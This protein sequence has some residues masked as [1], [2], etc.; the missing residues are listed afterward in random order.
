MILYEAFTINSRGEMK[1]SRHLRSLDTLVPQVAATSFDR[2]STM[3]DAAFARSDHAM[4]GSASGDTGRTVATAQASGFFAEAIAFQHFRA[5]SPLLEG[6]EG[7][8]FQSAFWLE[9]W[10]SVFCDAPKITPLLLVLRNNAGEIVLACP[11]V[12]RREGGLAFVEF[13]DRGVSDYAAPLLRRSAIETLPSGDALLAVVEAALP[14]AD[15]LRFE[16]LAP[17]VAGMPNP[18][19]QVS[20]ARKN[21]LSGWVSPSLTD[22]SGYFKRLSPRQQENSGKNL[23]RFLRHPGAAIEVHRD[24]RSAEAAL[25]RL[26]A[27]QHSR[28]CAKGL[29]YRL[30]TPTMD[31]F[32]RALVAQGIERG[33]TLLVEFRVGDETVAANFTVIAGQV[34]IYLRVA[35]QFGEWARMSPGVLVTE[36]AMQ[37][38]VQ[39]G[40]VTFDFGMGDYVYKR[41]LGAVEVPLYDIVVPLS[42]RGAPF[43]LLWHARQWASGNA[44]LR[45]LTGRVLPSER[46]GAAEAA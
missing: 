18:L 33:Q 20:R 2:N 16:R 8:P 31:A 21:R 3:T 11:L 9:C 43:A 15:I 10:Y 25:D 1:C 19:Y 17:H 46:R 36:Q 5:V 27:L 13:P 12:R 32:Y 7:G 38:A 6:L 29:D 28:I 40:A 44:L 45:R 37:E 42:L 23:R 22:W 4:A 34:A 41:R 39:R 30:N 35:N 24:C 14:D 26:D